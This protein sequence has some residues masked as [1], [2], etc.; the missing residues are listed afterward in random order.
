MGV[1]DTV[2]PGNETESALLLSSTVAVA[3]ATDK[4]PRDSY[5]F[6]YMIYFFLGFGYLLPWN[7]FITAIDYFSYLY[8]ETSVDRVFSV[9]YFLVG[10]VALLLIIY[11]SHKSSAFVR[12]NLGLG[13]FVVSL[14]M[15]PIMDAVYTKGRVGLYDGFYASV[16][17]VGIS[18]VADSLV[19]SGI[20]GQAGELPERYMQAVVVGTAGSGVLV[21]LLRILTKAIYPQDAAGLRKSA[22]LYFGVSIGVMFLCL[23]LYNISHRLPVIKYYKKLK[24]HAVAEEEVEKG[25]QTQSLWLSSIWEVV[26]T[27]KCYGFGIVLI[28]V[29]TLSIFPGYITED[30]H[31][32]TLKDWYPILL[33]T[34][35]NVFDLFGKCLTGVYL[36]KDANVAVFSCI[37]RLLFY[38]LFLECLHGPKFFRTEIPVIILTCLLGLTNGY[39][40]SVLFILAPKVVQLQHAETAGIVE[41]LF[42]VIG[43]AAGSIVGWFWIL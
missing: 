29:V 14:L 8:P 5:H 15:V 28:Y 2:D 10:L 7:A 31:S 23:I 32:Q 25:P 41:V 40:T 35:Y 4:A 37:A 36:L 33:M 30:V 39:L 13:L 21:S 42:L 22:R 19:Q 24:I 20:V 16:V 3:A 6:C 9:V 43:L 26:K 38:P 18:G 17:A 1:S 34:G 27:V 11:Y 12:I